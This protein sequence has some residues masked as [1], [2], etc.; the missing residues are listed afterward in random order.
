ML[1]FNPK[2]P[3]LKIIIV[4]ALLV[5]VN[6]LASMF[7]FRIDLTQEKRYSLSEATVN[8]LDNLNEDIII[9]VYLTGSLN[10][11]FTRLADATRQTLNEF[12][13]E[14][15]SRI[16]Y[17]FIDPTAE[18]NKEKREKFM[19]ELYEKGIVPTNVFDTE[20]GK[21]TEK[22][23]FPGAVLIA[24][25]RETTVQLL[26]GSKSAS[27]R[28]QL[29]QSCEN[30]EYQLASAIKT[31]SQKERKRIG[32]FPTYS[33]VP[34]ERQRDLWTSLYK[35]N[36]DVFPVDLSQSATL[37]SLDAVVLLKPDR[38][39]SEED[40]FKIDQFIMHGGKMVCLLDATKIDSV[41]RGEGNFANP[42]RT[43]I[44]DLLFKYGVR[45]NFTLL[46]DLECAYIPLVVGQQGNQPQIQ[47]TEWPYFPLLS[48]FGTSPI[49]RNLDVL[50]GR[51][52]GTIDTVKA[53]GVSKIPLVFTSQYTQVKNT[54]LLVSYNETRKQTDPKTFNAGVHTVAYLLEGKF[55]SFYKNQ[56]LPTDPRAKDFVADSPSTQI[57]VVADG[58]IA[59]NDVDSRYNQ[60]LPIG[61]DRFSK[62]TF[63]NKDFL[64][65]T[66]DYMLDENGIIFSRNKEIVLR[67][68][69]K[70][71]VQEQR[72][73]WQLINIVLPLVVLFL[74]GLG[75]FWWRR[76]RFA[77]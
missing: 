15:G 2:K 21:K 54:P 55:E 68:L 62:N 76:Q 53:N 71:A 51:F 17:K 7:F 47:P 27:A 34:A 73:R 14:A 25:N 16:S 59:L 42:N 44:E 52:V 5:A 63:G 46:K 60:I 72:S 35:R 11:D 64:M 50:F 41:G 48:R 19:A 74:F 23:V 28:E 39:F 45:F 20:D 67:P 49:V 69:D 3:F 4:L 65:N 61:Y 56:I 40:K 13:S 24:G 6:F 58:D 9:K 22:M 70:V 12:K 43:G 26:K 30:V 75:R 32:F 18:P 57:V 10:P 66:V 37:D 8:L 36:Y 29:N 38:V 31:I 33:S 1:S 77:A